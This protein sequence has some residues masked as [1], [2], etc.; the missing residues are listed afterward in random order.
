MEAIEEEFA[1][2]LEEQEKALHKL[3]KDTEKNNA[4]LQQKIHILESLVKN[5]VLSED[6]SKNDESTETKSE[7]DKLVSVTVEKTSHEH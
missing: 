1:S 5:L 4:T 2:K 6:N 7:E 3:I